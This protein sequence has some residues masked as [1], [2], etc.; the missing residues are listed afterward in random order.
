[1][2]HD[3]NGVDGELGMAGAFGTKEDHRPA[4]KIPQLGRTAPSVLEAAGIEKTIAEDERIGV[5][6]TDI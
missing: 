3:K 4:R 6:E 1:V 5:V 2:S